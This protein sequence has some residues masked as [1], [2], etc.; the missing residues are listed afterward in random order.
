MRFPSREVRIGT[1]ALG[2]N[3]PVRLQS[4]T[5]TTVADVKATVQQAIR[6]FEAGADYVRIATPDLQ[7]V[8]QLGTIKK[9]LHD[10]GFS[11]PL[12]ADIHYQPDLALEAARLVEKI[13]IN[14]G[15]YVDRPKTGQKRWSEQDY[16]RDLEKLKHRLAP[17]ISICKYYGT[18]I[19]IG[20]NM[21]SL[22]QRIVYKYGHTPEAMV[23]S[24]LE[25]IR[26][27]EQLSFYNTVISLKSSSPLIMIKAYRLMADKMPGEKMNYPMHLGVTEAGAGTDGRIKSAL[28]IGTLLK[29]GIGD[30]I[31]VSLTEDPEHEIPFAA[32]LIEYA[33]SGQHHTDQHHT[34]SPSEVKNNFGSFISK[35]YLTEDPDTLMIMSAVDL[36]EKLLLKEIDDVAIEAPHIKESG[37][38]QYIQEALMQATGRRITK[39][40]FISC[41]GC[42][43]TSY[44]IQSVLHDIQELAGNFPGLKIAVMGCVVNGPG[45]MA[46][47]DYGIMGSAKGM[48]WL[49]KGSQVIKKNIHP[50]S[51]ANELIILLKNDSKWYP[52]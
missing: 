35:S 43:R 41:P 18:A 11:N 45:E 19:R 29:S 13:R 21:G 3:N 17:L 38:V 6:I 20:T 15:N 30:T 27:F 26:I 25:F 28:G 40:E 7:S 50:E 1:I 14:P 39:T 44:D 52:V 47:A 5:N 9:A 2:G 33:Q 49:Y 16:E 8:R 23:H 36:G 34:D 51:A 31:R 32:K 4:M 24:T 10:A 46:D 48:L 22:S 37:K 42:A 12:I